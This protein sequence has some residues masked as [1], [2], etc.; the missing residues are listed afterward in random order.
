M[1][2]YITIQP[3]TKKKKNRRHTKERYRQKKERNF[4]RHYS[5]SPNSISCHGDLTVYNWPK[6]IQ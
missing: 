1:E 2:K 4:H 6:D 5:E 3:H